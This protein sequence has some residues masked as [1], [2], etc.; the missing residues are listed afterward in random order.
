MYNCD[1]EKSTTVCCSH[2]CN[3]CMAC[4]DL[5]SHNAITIEDA[6]EYFDAKIN[7]GNCVNCGACR[8]VCPNN[9]IPQMKKPYKWHQ[10]WA[11]ETKVRENSSS[12]GVA[13]EISKKFIE[14]G[15]YVCSCLFENGEFV[16]RIINSYE[17][18][19][20]FA[21]SKYVKSNPN[22]VYS[23]IKRLL[24]KN[25]V[26][27]IG[28]PCQVA[29]LKNYVGETKNLFTIDLICHGTP[30]PKVLERFLLDNDIK[31]RELRDIKFRVKHDFGLSENFKKLSKTGDCDFYM[32]AFL[33]GI[34]YT[35][36]CYACKFARLERCSDITIGDSWGS[37]LSSEQQQKGLSL[38]LCQTYKGEELLD[39]SNIELNE[40]DLDAAVA[41]NHQLE[42][43]TMASSKTT[44]LLRSIRNGWNFNLIFLLVM[45]KY[46]FKQ[47]IKGIIKRGGGK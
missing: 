3:G 38:I 16:F 46:G 5:C 31:I 37:K 24:R 18:I 40:V 39:M 4:V 19:L 14:K 45:P 26:L 7:L 43:P 47:L 34:S 44:F 22:G 10:G 12:G 20:P 25:K 42:K 9:N 8:I 2:M 29:G 1:N 30:S 23:K 13:S 33:E 17:D 15:G 27:F 28:L 6:V 32:K 11:K 41:S 36:N 21:G 35:K